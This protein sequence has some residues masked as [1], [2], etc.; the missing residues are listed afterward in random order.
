M[1]HGGDLLSYQHL[2]RGEL[3]DFSSNIN[4]LGYPKILNEIFTSKGLQVA[5]HYPDIHYRALRQAIADYLGCQPYEVMV[6]NGAVD[7]LDLLCRNSE[8]IVVCTPCFGEYLERPNI[9]GKPVLTIAM[10]QDFTVRARLLE[11]YLRE[12]DLLFLGNPN[13]PT[14]K[15]IRKEELLAIQALTEQV[16]AFLVLDEAFFEFCPPDYDSIRLF[17][18]NPHVCV[19]RA[20]TKFFGL[21]GIRLGYAYAVPQLVQHYHDIVLPWRINAFA[22]LA[23]QTIFQEKAYIKHSQQYMAEQRHFML[24]QLQKMERLQIYPTDANFIL[25]K[26]LH[27]TEDDLFLRLARQGFLIRKASSFVGLDDRFIRLAI[28]DERSNR[29][30]LAALQQEL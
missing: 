5:T 6:G 13:N 3:L 18:G 21:P 8:R 30:F 9:Q 22:D 16:G 26:L 10:E 27:T 24:E 20:A 19:I 2:Y 15:R 7:L 4:P 14:G 17:Y 29:R 25:V 12:N 11:Q 28:K 1:K 23:G